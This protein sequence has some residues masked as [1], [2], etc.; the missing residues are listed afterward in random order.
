MEV[1]KFLLHSD[2]SDLYK[3]LIEVFDKD[4]AKETMTNVLASTASAEEVQALT[5]VVVHGVK[6]LDRVTKAITVA[7]AMQMNKKLC[8]YLYRQLTEVPEQHP[9]ASEYGV[10]ITSKMDEIKNYKYVTADVFTQLTDDEKKTVHMIACREEEDIDVAADAYKT[11]KIYSYDFGDLKVDGKN[12]YIDGYVCPFFYCVKALMKNCNP[13]LE[14]KQRILKTDLHRLRPETD[15]E[16]YAIEADVITHGYP[17]PLGCKRIARR[18]ATYGGPR[19]HNLSDKLSLRAKKIIL[20]YLA[21]VIYENADKAWLPHRIDCDILYIETQSEHY[22]RVGS[23]EDCLHHLMQCPKILDLVD[24]ERHQINEI[25]ML[26]VFICDRASM[27][28]DF[29]EVPNLAKISVYGPDVFGRLH[30][31]YD[32]PPCPYDFTYGEIEKG[33]AL[34]VECV[35][36]GTERQPYTFNGVELCFT[37]LDI[38]T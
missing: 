36:A 2:A 7:E 33:E 24:P 6:D 38:A 16:I 20:P 3:S 26:Y 32:N 18:C 28:F 17:Y 1:P 21:T 23:N 11:L 15:S 31:I 9:Q 13:W 12:F 29:S 34:V 4:Q 25:R 35:Y 14:N 27:Q 30:S 8:Q 22:S 10:L 37:P 19:R 5:D